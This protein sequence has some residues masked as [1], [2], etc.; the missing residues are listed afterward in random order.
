MLPSGTG[1]NLLRF[2]EAAM[3]VI[4]ALS[5]PNRVTR[6]FFDCRNTAPEPADQR[7]IEQ[8]IEQSIALA[9]VDSDASEIVFLAA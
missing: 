6:V 8:A 2:I 4:A 3:S 9:Q 5:E 7:R 1:S